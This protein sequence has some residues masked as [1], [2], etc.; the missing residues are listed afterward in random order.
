[1]YFIMQNSRS[2]KDTFAEKEYLQSAMALFNR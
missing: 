1:M 2:L